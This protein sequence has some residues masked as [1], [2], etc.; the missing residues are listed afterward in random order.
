MRAIEEC[1]WFKLK[2]FDFDV[3]TAAQGT[4]RCNLNAKELDAIANRMELKVTGSPTKGELAK[5]LNNP[6]ALRKM[7]TRLGRM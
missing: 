3:V 7:A 2:S 1:A 4:A 6:H 5:R